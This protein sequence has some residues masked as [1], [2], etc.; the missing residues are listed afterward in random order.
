MTVS[1]MTDF[2]QGDTLLLATLPTTLLYQDSSYSIDERVQDLMAR[3]TLDETIAQIGSYWVYELQDEQGLSEE[4][5]AT[6]IGH[7]I[8]QITRIGG[9]STLARQEIARMG[10]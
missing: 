8:G 7:G 4:K 1:L 6:L 9:A 2:T 5:A 3:M 10:N